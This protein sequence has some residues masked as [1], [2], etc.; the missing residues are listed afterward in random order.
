MRESTDYIRTLAESQDAFDTRKRELA[1]LLS[2]V[3]MGEVFRILSATR[4]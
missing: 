4:L 1:Q 3:F 2:P